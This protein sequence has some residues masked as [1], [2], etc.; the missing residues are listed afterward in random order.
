[1]EA[2]LPAHPR[3]GQGWAGAGARGPRGLTGWALGGQ[4]RDPGPLSSSAEAVLLGADLQPDTKCTTCP[5]L[6]LHQRDG[7]CKTERKQ[8]SQGSADGHL[9]ARS[10]SLGDGGTSATSQRT[11]PPL[12]PACGGRSIPVPGPAPGDRG[13][14]LHADTL[15]LSQLWFI[16]YKLSGR[17]KASAGEGG[18]G[19]P[20][21]MGATRRGDAQRCHRRRRGAESAPPFWAAWPPSFLRSPEEGPS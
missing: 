1:M 13:P 7:H 12:V 8:P 11:P 6:D 3:R 20:L 4:G 5:A 14:L 21:V 18:P 15:F 9:R 10:S 2:S 17:G 19:P 16:S